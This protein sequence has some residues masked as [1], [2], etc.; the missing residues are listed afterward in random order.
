MMHFW[1]VGEQNNHDP[2]VKQCLA[3]EKEKLRH[4]NETLS[5]KHPDP[6]ALWLLRHEEELHARKKCSL[7]FMACMSFIA[8]SNR[9]PWAHG[10]H[11]GIPHFL[12]S[13]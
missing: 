3:T 4:G 5:S 7:H 6:K 2:E 10:N 8:C 13:H 11:S 1:G 12:S 9:R